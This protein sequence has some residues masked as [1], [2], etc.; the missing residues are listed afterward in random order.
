[1]KSK[2]YIVPSLLLLIF[3]VL[4]W[5]QG[6]SVGTD[7]CNTVFG[8]VGVIF[9][10]EMSLIIAFNTRG[11]S[12]VLMKKRVR[13][14]MKNIRD[15]IIG[16]FLLSLVP[17]KFQGEICGYSICLWINLKLGYITFLTWYV[18]VLIYNFLKIHQNYEE[19]EDAED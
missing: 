6:W 4:P 1:M 7:T 12:G 18:I 10:V 14:D 13:K 8:A 2:A 16:Y 5:L 3:P 15:V 9:S 19:L 17:E 11:V